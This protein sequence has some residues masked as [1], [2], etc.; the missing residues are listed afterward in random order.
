MEGYTVLNYLSCPEP[1]VSELA[2]PVHSTWLG[3]QRTDFSPH[4]IH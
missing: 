3:L 4:F 2:L 1:S